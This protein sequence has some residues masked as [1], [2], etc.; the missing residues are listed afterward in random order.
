VS[1]VEFGW[2]ENGRRPTDKRRGE[3]ATISGIM[4]SDG[5]ERDPFNRSLSADL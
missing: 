5:A 2:E 4:E 3:R 1:E